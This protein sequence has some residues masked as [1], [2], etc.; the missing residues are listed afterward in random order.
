LV[1]AFTVRIVALVVCCLL[2]SV[3][4]SL[5]EEFEQVDVAPVWAGHP[6]GFSIVTTEQFQYVGF[7]DPQRRMTVGQRHLD[8]GRW[9]FTT[10]PTKVKWDSH[11][12]I[13]ME[14][15]CRGYLHVSGNMHGD[16]LIYFRSMAPHDISRFQRLRMVGSL[17]RKV[18]YPQFL[19][20]GDG[21]LYFQYRHGKSGN[22]LRILNRY[23]AQTRS[24]ARLLSEPLFD[25]GGRMSAYLSGP[26]VGPDGYF[27]LVWMWRD[28]PFGSTNHDLSYARSLDLE[29]WESVDGEP[30]SLP[31]TPETPG[32]VVDP[33]RSGE[34]LV[35][36]A[37]GV[38]WDASGRPTISYSKYGDDGNSQWFN[39]RREGG[40]WKVH[41]TSDWQ[42]RWELERTG[43]LA[44]DISVAPVGLD[45]QGRLAQSFN[46]VEAGSGTWI[47]DEETLRPVEV[48][49]ERD[50]LRQLKEVESDFAGIEVRE[51]IFDRR[52]EYFL[53]WET[54]PM[55]RDQPREPP[56]PPPSMLRVVRQRSAEEE[57]GSGESG[58]AV[59]EPEEAGDSLEGPGEPAD[60]GAE[61]R[62]D[63]S[64]SEDGELLDDGALEEDGARIGRVI[65][66]I[67]DIF[68][69]RDP[70]E[71]RKL[72]RFVNRLHPRTKDWVVRQQLLFSTGDLYSARLLEESERHLRKRPYLYDV[73][74]RPV[75]Y[76]DGVVDVEVETRDVWTLSGGVSFTREGGE[77]DIAF[78]VNDDNFL[79][80]G[81]KF[82]LDH[83]K[84]V[85]RTSTELTYLDTNIRGSRAEVE[86]KLAH[87][88]DGD[89]QLLHLRRPF[90]ALDA[91][92]AKGITVLLEDRVDPIFELGELTQEFRHEIEFFEPWWGFSKGLREGSVTRWK[93]GFTYSSDT[94]AQAPDQLEDVLLPPDRTL[95]YPWLD[96]EFIQDRF[97]EARDLNRIARTEDINLGTRLQGRVGWSSP[98]FG[99]DE[100]LLVMGFNGGT[101]FRPSEGTLLFT[102]MNG[103]ARWGHGDFETIVVG[104]TTRF[105]WR[106]LGRHAFFAELGAA[107]VEDLDPEKQL[108]LGGDS[109]LRGYPLRYQS[110][111]RRFLLTL[112]QRFFTDFEIFKLA[113]VGGAVFF[114]VGRAWFQDDSMGEDLGVLKDVGFGLR[115]SSSRSSGQS[116]FHIDVAFPLDGDDSIDDVQFVIKTRESF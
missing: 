76:E 116:V 105:F 46:H 108:L 24:W 39:T 26:V 66:T 54:M 112:E 17:E 84:D 79:G 50:L 9:S 60:D 107:V 21:C 80:F 37:F 20:G 22:G 38:G 90:Y 11:N 58:V 23:D 35:A 41:Q 63:E 29:H 51:F 85:D 98:S 56:F 48:L 114:D 42:Y 47:L 71:N 87:N 81:R 83:S 19:K 13:A 104:A 82:G 78:K 45:R 5:G 73:E 95:S 10:L 106:N 57:R 36:I 33:V 65:I 15:D 2:L 115:V 93:L 72:F 70:S 8:S 43:A 99:A 32:V 12:S 3:T 97:V 59:A 44:W 101:G 103:G 109:G 67:A 64:A 28:T 92:R 31:I 75:R 100:E 6:V 30:L 61:A 69:Q 34:G 89:R 40:R 52:G 88:S 25:G 18:T 91:R 102:S 113:N 1:R 55:N 14:I 53:R 77:N 62:E 86:V 110:G 49:P 94:F 4:A 16:R 96:V 111:D 74:I 7:Y 27:H 68:D